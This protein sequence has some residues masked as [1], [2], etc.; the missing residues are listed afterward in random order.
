M[1]IS[2]YQLHLGKMA[3]I[4]KARTSCAAIF[5]KK[6]SEKPSQPAQSAQDRAPDSSIPKPPHPQ[7]EDGDSDRDQYSAL[8]EVSDREPV[9]DTP[10]TGLLRRPSTEQRMASLALSNRTDDGD[11][12]EALSEVSSAEPYER[13]RT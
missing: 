2:L 9:E 11:M 13:M 4:A 5:H 1:S 10:S 3:F 6:R 7:Q 8:S 12:F